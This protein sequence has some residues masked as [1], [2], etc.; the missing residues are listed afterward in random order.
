MKFQIEFDSKT[1]ISVSK[2]TESLLIKKLQNYKKMYSYIGSPDNYD[3]LV[4]LINLTQTSN[5]KEGETEL[6]DTNYFQLKEIKS[7][8][9]KSSK[10]I[11]CN[12][13][14]LINETFFN[15]LI[16][17]ISSYQH[18]KFYAPTFPSTPD[19]FF[20]ILEHP[21]ENNGAIGIVD[22]FFTQFV[23]YLQFKKINKLF[24]NRDF[25]NNDLKLWQKLSEY[26]QKNYKEW[27]EKF[28]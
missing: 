9:N 23:Q 13:D 15:Q 18:I 4:T 5:Y 3:N 17:K 2:I 21:Y 24:I 26:K 27:I 16:R 6:I 12:L 1:K 14:L 11:Q 10:V 28:S 7:T 25:L 8:F 22:T 19:T 20:V